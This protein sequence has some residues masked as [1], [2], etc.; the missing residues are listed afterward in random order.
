MGLSSENEGSFFIEKI[1]RKLGDVCQYP[2]KFT[3]ENL[4]DKAGFNEVKFHGKGFDV[5]GDP[6]PRFIIHAKK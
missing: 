1:K 4:L 2:N 6:L 5:K 3:I